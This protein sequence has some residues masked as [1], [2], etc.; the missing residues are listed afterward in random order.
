M[1]SEPA[2]GLKALCFFFFYTKYTHAHTVMLPL[3]YFRI[4]IFSLFTHKTKQNKRK[5]HIH[6]FHF[7]C[8]YT[9]KQQQLQNI[10]FK[11]KKRHFFLF[12]LCCFFLGVVLY[13]EYPNFNVGFVAGSDIKA[14]VVSSSILSKLSLF[15]LFFK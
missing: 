13:V 6:A 9:H 10:R 7:A 12:T 2:I 14:V 1:P 8:V 5:A 3:L 4:Q 15:P 11:K